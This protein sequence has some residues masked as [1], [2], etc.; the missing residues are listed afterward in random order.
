MSGEINV[1]QQTQKIIVD[2]PSSSVAVISAGPAGPSGAAGPPGPAGPA[3]SPGGPPGPQGPKGDKGDPGTPAV[4]MTPVHFKAVHGSLSI[5]RVIW[6]DVTV[7]N[8]PT[9]NI[10]GGSFTNGIYTVPIAGRYEIIAC[11][12]YVIP[13]YTGFL[14]GQ[15]QIVAPGVGPIPQDIRAWTNPTSSNL[16][17]GPVICQRV[18]P[19]GGTIKIQTYHNH[20]TAAMSLF[21]NY[22]GMEIHRVE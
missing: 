8:A 10:G 13:G 17:V 19:A 2:P 7:W 3:G 15:L 14:V 6:T 18:C 11:I 12:F 21:P 20:P 5:P 9:E 22:V 16:A 1:V 4:V